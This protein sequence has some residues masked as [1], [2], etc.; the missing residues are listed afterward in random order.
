MLEWCNSKGIS[1]N[2]EESRFCKDNLKY[3]DFM[4]SEK[5][6]KPDT[7]KIQEIQEIPAPE[8]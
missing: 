3:Y 2:L 4:F 1:L 5:G 8:K 7:Q 6:M